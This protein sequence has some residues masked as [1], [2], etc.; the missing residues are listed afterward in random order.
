MLASYWTR[1]NISS[2]SFVSNHDKKN[3]YWLEESM[4]FGSLLFSHCWLSVRR[5]AGRK[6]QNDF[7]PLTLKP[8]VF[9][10]LFYLMFGRLLSIIIG[11]VD[12]PKSLREPPT[13]ICGHR[14][15][16]EVFSMLRRQRQF[17]DHLANPARSLTAEDLQ[18][19][20]GPQA[21]SFEMPNP[22]WG[23]LSRSYEHYP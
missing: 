16:R 2:R 20:L 23:Q 11:Y 22:N 13:Y 15:C 7:G 10:W 3:S 1:N 12:D 4:A 9:C 17:A 5:F 21:S 8:L 14:D 6:W 19:E 18:V